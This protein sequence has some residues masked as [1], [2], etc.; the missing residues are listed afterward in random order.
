MPDPMR[1]ASPQS[2]LPMGTYLGFDFGS[3]RIGVACGNTE[4]K[5]SAPLLVVKNHNGTPE[6]NKIDSLVEQWQPCAMVVGIPRQLDGTLE[7]I[8]PHANG[9]MR[10]LQSRYAIPVFAADERF[11][12]IE[13]H[14]GLKTRRQLGLSNTRQAGE[15]DKFAAAHILQDW[16]EAQ[17]NL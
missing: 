12:S 5:S 7:A 14:R 10:R 4:T 16:F 15:I 1:G 17:H 13:A 9:F 3:K 8:A 2:S 6:W 11:S